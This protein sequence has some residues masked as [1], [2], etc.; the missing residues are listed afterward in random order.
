MDNPENQSGKREIY[1]CMYCRMINFASQKSSITNG[2][3]L[4]DVP[5]I[6]TVFN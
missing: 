6:A 3:Y 5:A 4:S 2:A 1:D